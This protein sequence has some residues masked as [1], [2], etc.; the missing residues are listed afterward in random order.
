MKYEEERS[1]RTR[2]IRGEITNKIIRLGEKKR[3]L[4]SLL[5]LGSTVSLW[6]FILRKVFKI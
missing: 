4:I 1:K 6:D 3:S 2:G 5:C